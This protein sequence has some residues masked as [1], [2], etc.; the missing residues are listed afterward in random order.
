MG[1]ID[2]DP[3]LSIVGSAQIQ[4]RNASSELN[5]T[6]FSQAAF[7]GIADFYPVRADAGRIFPLVPGFAAVGAVIF[8]DRFDQGKVLINLTL[9][10]VRYGYNWCDGTVLRIV[11]LR[12]TDTKAVVTLS[13]QNEK[14]LLKNTTGNTKLTLGSGADIKGAFFRKLL[15]QPFRSLPCFIFVG[16]G[17]LI[18]KGPNRGIV[19][20]AHD[21]CDLI[22]GLTL[23]SQRLR[24]VGQNHTPLMLRHPNLH[25]QIRCGHFQLISNLLF[26]LA[27][28]LKL[29]DTAQEIAAMLEGVV[30]GTPRIAP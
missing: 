9:V 20:V 30:T 26:G 21:F 1:S 7:L 15:L 14:R 3:D 25:P 19:V 4:V 13:L 12:N 24:P 17:V 6:I 18:E 10:D 2:H 23:F 16:C 28:T 29:L 11:D 8:T 5:D 27:L 22:K